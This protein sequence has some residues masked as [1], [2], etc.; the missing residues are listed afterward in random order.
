MAKHTRAPW[1]MDC[2]SLSMGGQIVGPPPAPDWATPQERAANGR[3]ICAALDLLHTL[4]HIVNIPDVYRALRENGELDDTV[5]V[6]RAAN[7]KA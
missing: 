1:K 2:G 7:G 5:R 4:E 6:I 3:L